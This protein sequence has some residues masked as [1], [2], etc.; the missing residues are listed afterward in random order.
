[1]AT[2]Q[3]TQVKTALAQIRHFSGLPDNILDEIATAA[4]LRRLNAGNVIYLEGE[5]A[6][7]VYILDVRLGKSHSHDTRGPRAGVD[8]PAPGRNFR[9]CVCRN[10]TALSR[11]GDCP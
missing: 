7:A 1:M 3:S 5:P 6:E 2:D 8:G 4:I 10:E 11:H 9:R